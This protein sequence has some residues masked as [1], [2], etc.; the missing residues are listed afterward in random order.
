MASTTDWRSTPSPWLVRDGEPQSLAESDIRC[1]DG[2][3]Q[4]PLEIL[5]FR[6]KAPGYLQLRV[7]LRHADNGVCYVILEQQDDHVG[8]R[9][10]ACQSRERLR[11]RSPRKRH[12]TDC[13]CNL[14]LAAPL[15]T[16]VVIDLDS[17][18]ELRLFIPRWH[19]DEPSEYIPRPPGELWHPEE[20][21]R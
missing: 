13:P 5:G 6:L 11:S 17:G 3:P 15:G 1:P 21:P 7:V 9:A 10:A 12:E 2:N 16:R 8:V 18:E 4:R 19:L 14:D 20:D